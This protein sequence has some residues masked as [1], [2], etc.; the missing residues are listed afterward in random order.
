[1]IRSATPLAVLA[2]SAA[3]LAGPLNPPAGPIISTAKPL[4]EVEPRTPISVA[5]TPGDSDSTFKISQPGSYYLIANV[6]GA[7]GKH[8]IEIT[9]DNVTV[10]LNGFS[11]TGAPG[12][13]AAIA[14]TTTVTGVAV[15]NGTIFNWPLGGVVLATGRACLVADLN[16]TSV[17]GSAI[18]VQYN[19]V[20]RN[21]TVDDPLSLTTS[22]GIKTGCCTLVQGCHVQVS[23]TGADGIVV[24]DGCT[25]RD[26]VLNNITANGIRA[27][28]T[29]NII[30]NCN[31]EIAGAAGITVSAG[32]TVRGCAVSSASGAAI[33]VTG[34]DTRIERNNVRVSNRGLQ[35]VSGATG[36]IFLGNTASGNVVNFDIV[37]GNVGLFVSG[38][39]GGAVSG[40]AGGVSPG[41]T[42]S[43]TNYSY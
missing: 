4:S 1:M 21:C 33:G 2:L 15:K 39:T 18:Q 23:G 37:A 14:N 24:D 5:T 42:D 3:A 7:A 20:V 12:A 28:F 17:G 36:N 26:C 31:V 35:A 29:N 27:I 40:N 10:D 38:A 13:F 19:S 32:C 43:N 6:T 8:G 25:V 34:T 41:S 9:S 30:E 11:M 16:V 22:A